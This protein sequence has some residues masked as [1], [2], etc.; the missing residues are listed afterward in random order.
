MNARPFHLESV[1]ALILRISK[2]YDLIR[3]GGHPTS[4][5]QPDKF[6][7]TFLRKTNKY[8]VHPGML[9]FLNLMIP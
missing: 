8:W 5:S 2:I 1:D 9:T 3:T 6:Q 4:V 7:N